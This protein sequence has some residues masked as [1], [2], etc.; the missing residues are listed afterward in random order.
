M[1]EGETSGHLGVIVD[2]FQLKDLFCAQTYDELTEMGA[3]NWDYVTTLNETASYGPLFGYNPLIIT[4][5]HWSCVFVYGP[6]GTIIA[7]AGMTWTSFWP[8]DV[9]ETIADDLDVT[10]LLSGLE[11]AD[12]RLH[13]YLSQAGFSGELGYIT[14]TRREY[15]TTLGTS[16]R[17]HERY[18]TQNLLVRENDGLISAVYSTPYWEAGGDTSSVPI[19]HIEEIPAENFRNTV[20]A[21]DEILEPGTSTVLMVDVP[22]HTDGGSTGRYIVGELEEYFDSVV[23]ANDYPGDS[24]DPAKSYEEVVLYVLMNGYQMYT[25]YTSPIQLP[26]ETHFSYTA[27]IGSQSWELDWPENMQLWSY[28]ILMYDHGKYITF[29]WLIHT[30]D[31]AGEGYQGACLFVRSTDPVTKQKTYSMVMRYHDVTDEA[32]KFTVKEDGSM[33]TYQYFAYYV[34]D[35]KMVANPVRP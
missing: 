22:Y 18:F 9:Y 21:M 29:S 7:W 8:L 34:P 25:Y 13:G 1:V 10:V 23:A 6:A 28:N 16:T 32:A 14:E 11:H 30:N 19:M 27:H 17:V 20:F 4:R 15:D 35:L 24:P 12:G 3:W 2:T 31:F 33:A 5:Q 26:T